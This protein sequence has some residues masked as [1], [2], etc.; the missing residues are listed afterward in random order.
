MYQIIYKERHTVLILSFLIIIVSAVYWQVR[1]HEFISYDD[2]DYVTDNFKVQ[3][4]LTIEG[5][6]WAF[7]FSRKGDRTYYHPLTWL[8][9]MLDCEL[10]GLDPSGHHI[11]NIIFHALNVL[12]LFFCLK[13]STGEIY[14]SAFVAALFALHPI[15]VDSVAWIAERKNLLSAFFWLLSIMTYIW[16]TRNNG[17]IRYCMVLVT[18]ALGLLAKPILVTLSFALLLLDYWPLCRFSFQPKKEK[19]SAI[20]AKGL[21]LVKEKI[22]LFLLSAIWSFLSELSIQQI[23][24]R[25]PLLTRPMSLRINNA[26]VSYIKYIFKLIWPFDLTIFYPYP[27]HIPFWQTA[28]VTLLLIFF[29]YWMLRRFRQYPWLVVGWLWYLGTLFPVL[30]LTQNGLW[31]EMADRWAYLPAIGIFIM[32]GWGLYNLSDRISIPKRMVITAVS[33]FF[34]NMAFITWVQLNYWHDNEKLFR[35][36]IDVTEN[37][38]VGHNNLGTVLMARND[39]EGA[40]YHFAKAEKI[41]PDQAGISTNMGI[42]LSNLGR[43]NEALWHFKNALRKDPYDK[44]THNRLGVTLKRLKRYDEAIEHFQKAIQ[45][46]PEYADAYNN[47]GNVLKIKHRMDDAL[48]Y[49]QKALK[50]KPD[51]PEILNNIGTVFVIKS[52]F[53][54]AIIYYRKAIAIDP[55][56]P[57]IHKNLGDIYRYKGNLN[58]AIKHYEEALK[59]KPVFV[60]AHVALGDVLLNQGKVEKAERH[61]RKALRLEP[62]SSVT[63]KKLQRI[64]N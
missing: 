37:N 44:K 20:C 56:N 13:I 54:S 32:I 27:K 47:L 6:K 59:A 1:K 2:P 19:L 53:D 40:I 4:G 46:S 30:G 22:P 29:S 15:N 12:L 26:I 21:G 23:D 39:L 10:F 60:K 52:E 42:A 41:M 25:V 38:A 61:Y 64:L 49:Y 28:I 7:R 58:K 14:P 62:G 43:Q 33:F 51:S 34:V 8:S 45:L 35:H 36:A 48:A 17:R 31:P 57:T 18:M 55:K 11:V 5:V 9:H 63:R 3:Q 50:L 24:A 16:Y